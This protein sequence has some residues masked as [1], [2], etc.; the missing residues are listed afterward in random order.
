MPT[1]GPER[2][3][4]SV[5]NL[6]RSLSLYRDWIGMS[7]KGDYQL[8]EHEISDFW[9]LPPGTRAH[10]VLL[11][12]AGQPTLLELLEFSP[13]PHAVI[14][15][16]ARGLYSGYWGLSFL[17][18][19]IDYL[20][21]ELKEKGYQWTGDLS[22]FNPVYLN[23]GVRHAVLDGPD[24]VALYHFERLNGEPWS[25]SRYIE[26]NHMALVTD[27][28]EIDALKRFFGESIGLVPRG[29][30]DDPDHTMNLLF[31]LPPAS[32]GREG[33]F[34]PAEGK[35]ASINYVFVPST[36]CAYT[37]ESTPPNLGMFQTSY[38]VDNLMETL[39][40]CRAAGF[41]VRS[42]PLALKSGHPGKR[43]AASVIGPGGLLTE[44]YE[45]T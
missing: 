40:K 22:T 2:I 30:Y 41:Q 43:Q 38:R 27:E 45:L 16:D 24:H 15:P 13:G 19:D 21:K 32:T 34:V 17:V 26:L 4:L 33:F 42:G 18:R 37:T 3:S 7:Q 28:V 29:E 5:S 9:R 1:Y 11:Q 8:D 12:S 23:C 36:G 20:F 39:A 35:A 44:L 10:S 14:R 6:D 31:D 25:G